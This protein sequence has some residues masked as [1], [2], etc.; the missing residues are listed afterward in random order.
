MRNS[1][2][3]CLAGAVA[4]LMRANIDTDAISPSRNKIGPATTDFAPFL[5]SEWRYAADGSEIADFVL[6]QPG[7]RDAMFL[8]ALDNFG[9]GSSRESAPWALRDFGFRCIIA[10]SFGSIFQSNCYRNGMVPVT[11]DRATVELLGAA[12]QDVSFRLTLDLAT[13]SL[14]TS[15]G[16]SLTFVLDPIARK[17]VMEGLDPIAI[18]LL[19][20]SEIDEFRA[21]DRLVRPWAYPE[22]IPC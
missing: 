22:H 16:T 5:F 6:N 2:L 4:P 10:P 12:A 18:T 21:S 8:I 14:T 9:C 7:R 15:T 11:L 17:M 3:I 1:P 13:Q 20:R 19:R